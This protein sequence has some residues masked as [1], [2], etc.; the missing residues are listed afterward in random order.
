MGRRSPISPYLTATSASSRSRRAIFSE[1]QRGSSRNE[2]IVVC[3]GIERS[4]RTPRVPRNHAG[5]RVPELPVQPLRRIAFPGVGHQQRAA[6]LAAS[7]S[8]R[9]INC[10]PMRRRLTD[11]RTSSRCTSARCH[12][13]G[14][15]ASS[16]CTEVTS[17]GPSVAPSLSCAVRDVSSSI[18]M[19]GVRPAC[20]NSGRSLNGRPGTRGRHL[21]GDGGAPVSTSISTC[22]VLR[23]ALICQR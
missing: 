14:F 4:I 19:L 23:A 8:S 13:F 1:D 11:R 22:R 3:R 17:F 18:C 6:V 5:F 15:R 16:S 7:S 9:R 2:H 21:A 12:A 10:S 20:Q